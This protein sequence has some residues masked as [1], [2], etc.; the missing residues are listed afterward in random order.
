MQIVQ[1]QRTRIVL[2]G[3]H[4][5]NIYIVTFLIINTVKE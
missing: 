5:I 2:V 1:F 4:D 3:R